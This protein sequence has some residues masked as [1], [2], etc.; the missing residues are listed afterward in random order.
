[1]DPHY[2]GS[3]NIENILDG[4][5]CSWKPGTFWSKKDFYNLLV[6]INKEKSCDEENINE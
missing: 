2:T 4:G 6:V 3:D 1:L 5:W